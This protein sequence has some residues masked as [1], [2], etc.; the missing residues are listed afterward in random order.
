MLIQLVIRFWEAK[1]T[2]GIDIKSLTISGTTALGVDIL[3]GVVKVSR[4]ANTSLPSPAENVGGRISFYFETDCPLSTPSGNSIG[5]IGCGGQVQDITVA[6]SGRHLETYSDG[7]NWV[8]MR[9][10]GDTASITPA[11]LRL[12]NVANT[13]PS[14][15]PIY[16]AVPSTM[17]LNANLS[18]ANLAGL[19]QYL[20]HT[21]QH[22]C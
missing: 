18:Q 22:V 1:R 6:S 19:L 4:T 17:T 14:N 11:I 3:G 5:T 21:L 9:T 2:G 13:R 16:N 10:S 7:T 20:Q 15:L 12:G 8:I